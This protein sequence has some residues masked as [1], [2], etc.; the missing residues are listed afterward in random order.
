MIRHVI[1]A[2]RGGPDAKSRLRVRLDGASRSALVEAMLADMLQALK[3]CRTGLRVQVTTPTPALADMAKRSGA[4]V[5]CEADGGD[6]NSALDQARFGLARRDPDATVMLLPGDLP[7]LDA[8]EVDACFDLL[9]KG[10][11]VLAPASAD[12]GTGALV[13]DAATALPLA[14]GPGSFGK[15][16]AATR[17]VGLRPRIVRLASLGFDLDRPTDLDAFLR[18][19]GGGRTADLLRDSS[20]PSEAAA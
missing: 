11:V 16:L 17:A 2:A 6:L 7:R 13:F 12:G 14:F 19:G 4:A 5:I 20:S 3:G 18:H 1:I 15:H 10:E 8:A 9:G